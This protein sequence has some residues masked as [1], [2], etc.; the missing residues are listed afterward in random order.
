ACVDSAQIVVDEPATIT[1]T[2]STSPNTGGL[3]N[4]NG[5]ASA[6]AGGGTSPYSIDWIA[7]G[8]GDTTFNAP[9]IFGLCDG[10]YVAVITDFNGCVSKD[11]TSVTASG[12]SCTNNIEDEILAGITTFQLF[13]NPTQSITQLRL[14]LDRPEAIN[15][16]LVNLHG[17]LIEEIQ[18]APTQQ[19][20]HNLDVSALSAGVYFVRVET[21][22]GR[23]TQRLMVD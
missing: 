2:T 15:I 16:K 12:E 23:A 1:I 22:R 6:S 20:N 17:Q 8:S 9:F 14:E 3:A 5:T 4:P 11:T 21:A 13:P 18:I 7:V 19:L 10:D